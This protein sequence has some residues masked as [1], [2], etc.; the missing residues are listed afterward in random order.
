MDTRVISIGT[1]AEHPLRDTSRRVRTGHATTTL[2]RAGDAVILVDPG[3]P[4]AAVV[5]RLDERAGLDPGDV[6]HVF[7]TS[8]KA[9][10][11]RGLRAFDHADWFLSQTERESVGVP[12]AQLLRDAGDA[13]PDTREELEYQVSLLREC[14]PAPDSLARG[15]D[16]FPL[17]GVTPGLTGLLLAE[18]DRTTVICGD[19]IPTIE[20]YEQGRVLK[21]AFDAGQAMESFREAVE[22]ADVLVPGRDN[23]LINRGRGIV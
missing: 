2:V 6:T 13:D 20:H 22:I 3:L 18:A 17:P 16:L 19:A 14:K 5:A 21:T 12:L 23:V 15:V 11:C 7:L 8:F 10:T 4:P 9:D 1:M